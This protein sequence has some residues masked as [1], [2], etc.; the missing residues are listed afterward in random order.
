MKTLFHFL[1]FSVLTVVLVLAAGLVQASPASQPEAPENTVQLQLVA[2]GLNRPV[3][4]AAP[5]DDRGRL[6]ILE[7]PGSIRI[8]T[9]AGG[10][11]SLLPTPFLNITALVGSGGNEQGLLGLAFHP[12]YASNGYFYVN[13]TNP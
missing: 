7:K 6:F 3:D 2:S 8:V 9:V 11:Y 5:A 1:V 10:V 4:L 13:Y 12:N